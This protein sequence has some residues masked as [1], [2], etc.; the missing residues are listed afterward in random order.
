MEQRESS[1]E[2]L[3]ASMATG[4]LKA[5]GELV[6]RHQKRA[7]SLSY[8]YLG[9][10]D[11]AEEVAQ[12]AFLRVCQSAE[13]YRPS[14]KFTTWL[15]R[16]VVNLCLDHIRRNKRRPK[17]LGGFLADTTAKAASDSLE[18][19][20]QVQKVRQSVANLPERQRR[21]VILHRYEE[22]SH[23]EISEVTGWSKS[24]VE[25]LL[26]RAYKNLRKTLDE[27]R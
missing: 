24:T 8:R 11:M 20:E 9:S 12:E 13:R 6:R 27:V 1:D 16:I 14:S 2:D 15:Y 17:F 21:A 10:W 18:T 23:A 19:Q 25:S 4:D 5:L 7:L 26:V 22:L 3:M